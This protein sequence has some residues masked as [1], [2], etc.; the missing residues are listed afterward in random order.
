M[1]VRQYARYAITASGY[2]S[3]MHR[4]THQVIA[5]SVKLRGPEARAGTA[6]AQQSTDFAER[7]RPRGAVPGKPARFSEASI[8]SSVP[9]P[10]RYIYIYIY[11]YIHIHIYI[12]TYIHIYIYMHTYIH[13]YIYIYIYIHTYIHTYIY[14]YIHI[15]IYICVYIHMLF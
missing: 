15:C 8:R 9:C 12:H 7:A 5:L 3:G 2:E 4:G 13:T 14:I 11:I 1:G 6:T 10:P